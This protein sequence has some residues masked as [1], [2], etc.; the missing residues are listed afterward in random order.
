MPPEFP[1][2]GYQVVLENRYSSKSGPKPLL[3][4][5]FNPMQFE[6]NSLKPSAIIPDKPAEVSQTRQANN[7]VTKRTTQT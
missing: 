2:Q 4:E 5:P 7:P 3:E 6:T 1:G